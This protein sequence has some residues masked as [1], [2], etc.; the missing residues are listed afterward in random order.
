MRHGFFRWKARER[1][2]VSRYANRILKDII[3]GAAMSAIVSKE[4]L[5][6]D[7]HRRWLDR[8]L[9]RR[10]ARRNVARSL[11][12]VMWGMWKSGE[13]YRPELVAESARRPVMA[14]PSRV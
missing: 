7:Q 3:L 4:N 8:G 10:N 13:A 14:E 2:R 9:S 12:T 5:F 6:A 1:V 11:A